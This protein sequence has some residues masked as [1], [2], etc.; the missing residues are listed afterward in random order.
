MDNETEASVG[1]GAALSLSGNLS[2]IATHHGA[3]TTTADGTATGSTAVGASIALGFVDDSALSTLARGVTAG[4][5][6][7]LAAHGDGSSITTAKASAAGEASGGTADGQKSSK[8]SQANT[9]SGKTKGTT[10]SASSD[11]GSVSVGAALAVNVSSSTAR[12][13]VNDGLTVVAGN[14]GAG[15]LSLLASN[16]MDAKAIADGSA[17]T[18]SGGTAVGVAVSI[19]VA[20]MTNEAIVGAGTTVTADSLTLSAIMKNVSSNV[21]HDFE[22]KST[23]GAS[24]GDVG[25]A[26][27]FALS[28]VHTET[29]AV[30][31]RDRTDQPGSGAASLALDGGAVSMTATNTTKSDVTATAAAA[32]GGSSTGVGASI[33]LGIQ[34]NNTDAGIEDGLNHTVSG[35]ASSLQAAATANHTFT[36]AATAGAKGGTAVG[37]AIAIAYVEN[38]TQAVIGS[39]GGG[40]VLT[41]GTLGAVADYIGSTV[42]TADAKASGSTAVGLTIGLNIGFADTDAKIARSITGAGA[43]NVLADGIM[44]STVDVSASAGGQSSGGASSDSETSNKTGVAQGKGGG[45]KAP[46]QTGSSSVGTANTNSNTQSGQGTGSGGTQ[47][48]AAVAVNYLDASTD[49]LIANNVTIGASGAVKVEVTTQVTAK[50][51]A[52]ATAFDSNATTGVAAAVGLNISEVDAKARIGN[53]ANVTGSSVSVKSVLP[54][55]AEHSYQVRALAG[56]A[57][58]GT[59][60][61]GSI[62]VNYLDSSSVA[63]IGNFATVTATGAGGVSV[64]ADNFNE[65][66]NLA[67]GAAL[68][69]SSSAGVGIAVAV[70]IVNTLETK[71]T[72][73]SDSTIN[74]NN[75]P[76]KVAADA[77]LVPFTENF[78]LAGLGSVPLSFTN[79][80]AGVAASSGGS[81][82]GGSASVNVMFIRTT[83]SVGANTAI[84]AGGDIDVTADDVMTLFT[85][86]GGIGLS[87]G[88]A[89]VGIGIDVNVIDRETK[90]TIGASADLITTGGDIEVSADSDDD[91]T[92]IAVTFGV[93][94]SGS[95]VS[96]SIGVLVLLTDT[97]TT[98]SDGT[99]LNRTRL[100]AGGDVTVRA[101][102]DADVFMLAGGL[103]YGNSAGIGIASTVFVH[104]DNVIASIGTFGDVTTGGAIGLNVESTSV[105]DVLLIAAAG[106]VTGGSVG[107]GGSVIVSVMTETTKATV[108]SSTTV[109]ATDIGS[110]APGARV[111]ADSDTDILAVAGAIGAAAGSAGIGAGVNVHTLTKTTEAHIA[112]SAN[113]EAEGNVTVEAVSDEVMK[114]FSLAAGGGSSIGVGISADVYVF[115]LTTRAYIGNSAI[116]RT[117]G[118]VLV[119]A[120]DETEADLIVGGASVGGTGGV[121][122]AVGVVVIDKIVDAYIGTSAHVTGEGHDAVSART[123]KFVAGVGSVKSGVSESDLSLSGGAQPDAADLEVGTPAGVGM[124]DKDADND[125]TDDVSD[126]PGLSA[127]QTSEAAVNANFRGVAV[128]ASSKDDVESMSF[129]LAAG[130]TFGVGVAAAVNVVDVDT[131]ATIGQ[132][133]QINQSVTGSANTGQSV[134]IAAASDFNHVGIGVGAA[135]GGSAGVAPG[136][137]VSVVEVT[138]KAQ[139]GA[140]TTVDARDDVAV[141]ATAEESFLIIA[142]GI[143]ASGA[144]ALGGGVSVITVNDETLASI[145]D[146]ADV[147][148]GG[149][150]AVLAEDDSTVTIITGGVGIGIGGAGIGASVGI[151]LFDK[152]TD[153]IIGANAI[154]NAKGAGTGY[155]EILNGDVGGDG[156]FTRGTAHGVIVQAD[157]TESFTNVSFAGAG[158]VYAGIAGAIGVTVIDSDTTAQIGDNA[159]INQGSGNY[160]VLANGVGPDQGVWVG[161]SNRVELLQLSIGIA[162]G[163]AGIAGAI[164]IG[165]IAN[166]VNATIGTGA[167]VRARSMVEVNAL[168]DK[169]LDGFT[170][171]GAGGLVGLGASVSVYSLGSTFDAGYEDNEGNSD[172]AIEGDGTGDGQN[173]ADGE[174][175][176]QANASSGQVGGSIGEMQGEAA[177]PDPGTSTKDSRANAGFGLAQ[178]KLT[179]GSATTSGKLGLLTADP[180]EPGVIAEVKAGGS[181]VTAGSVGVAAHET[182]EADMVS[183][184]LAVG[185]V[186]AGAAV[187]ILNLS[188]NVQ[189]RLGGSVT[190]AGAV[191]VTANGKRVADMLT[192]GLQAGFVGV[193]AAVS[194]LSDNSVQGAEVLGGASI[195]DASSVLVKAT[196]T[197][198][199]TANTY[200]LQG[201]V[202][203]LGVNFTR[204]SADDGDASTLDTYATIGNGADIGETQSVGTVTVEATSTIDAYAETVGVAIGLVAGGFNFSF[205]DVTPQVK[206]SIGNNVEMDTTGLVAL[207]A[208]T[209]HDANSRLI[210]ASVG[211]V[212]VGVS[213]AKATIGTAVTASIGSGFEASL[214]GL[215]LLASHNWGT[216]NRGAHAYAVAAGGGIVSGQGAVPTANAN[217]T[218]S[219][220]IGAGGNISANSGNISVTSRL[221]NFAEADALAVSIGIAGVGA[222]IAHANANGSVTA[223]V[224]GN[225]TGGNNLDVKAMG[226][227]KARAQ[228]DAATGGLIAVT[229]PIASAVASPTLTARLD[230]GA[231]I[232]GAL[233]V[234]ANSEGEAKAETLSITGGLAGIGSMT[235]EATVSPV[236]ISAIGGGTIVA[237][238]VAV[239]AR[240]NFNT[241]KEA[242]ARTKAAGFT[243]VGVQ[244]NDAEATAKANLD[245]YIEGGTKV[246]APNG[247]TISATGQNKA[248]ARTDGLNVGILVAVGVTDATAEAS[249]TAKAGIRDSASLPAT[250]AYTIGGLN[251][252][253]T[254]QDTASATVITAGGGIVSVADNDAV[255]KANPVV[256]AYIGANTSILATGN[257]SVA[258]LARPEADGK[259]SGTSGGLVDVGAALSDVDV[260]P[261]VTASIKSASVIDTTGSVTVKA[262]ALPQSNNVPNYQIILA[263]Q[264]EDT[265][266][267]TSHGLETGDVVE[268]DAD[269]NPNTTGGTPIS[270]LSGVIGEIRENDDGSTTTVFVNR[271]YGVIRIDDNTVAF[272]NEFAGNVIDTDT[273]II[274]FG[275]AHN[276]ISG[277]RVKYYKAPG[278]V[279]DVSGLNTAATYFVLVVDDLSIKLVDTQ[280]KA[281]NPQN[282]FKSF[283]PTNVV[284]GTDT[285]TLPNV[286]DLA[287]GD[288]VTYDAPDAT[289]FFSRQVDVT[290]GAPN[291]DGSANLTDNA[292]ANNIHFVNDNGVSTAHGFVE[293]EHVVYNVEAIS[294]AVIPIGGLT[295][296]VTYRV[297]VINSTTIQLK[298]NDVIAEEVH[299][300][301]D[302]GTQRIVRTDGESWTANGFGVGDSLIVTGVGDNNG[303]Y[304]ITAASGATLTLSAA[305]DF[306]AT[307]VND[308]MDFIRGAA[309]GDK[310]QIKWDDGNWTSEGFVAGMVITVTNAGANNGSYTIDSVSTS[311]LTLTSS[312]VVVNATNDPS[313]VERSA[314]TKTFD[315]DVIALAPV[316]TTVPGNPPNVPDDIHS[317]INAKN[318]PIGGL[319]DGKT[320]YVRTISGNDITL[321]DAPA[322]ALVVLTPTSIPAGSGY[323]AHKLGELAVDISAG[324]SSDSYQLR[325]DITGATII[326][327]QTL[328]APGGV[329]LAVI[330]PQAGDG[331]SSTYAKGVSG[332]FIGVSAHTARVDMNPTVNADISAG[333]VLAGGDVSIIT[334]A[335]TDAKGYASN[336]AGAFIAVG[337]A[338]VISNQKLTS[339]ASVGGGT[340]ITAGNNFLIDSESRGNATLSTTTKTGGFVGLAEATTNSDMDFETKST[341]GANAVILAGDLARLY[342]TSRVRGDAKAN[343]TGVG[344]GGDGTATARFTTNNSISE[345]RL[346]SGAILEANRSVLE[347]YVQN[348]N[349]ASDS[350]GRGGGFYSEGEADSRSTLEANT[351]VAI[352]S[353]AELTGWEGVDLIAINRNNTIKTDAYS[354]SSGLFG[355]VDSDAFSTADLDARV[356]G[357]GGALVTAGPRD[358]GDSELSQFDY[359]EEPPGEQRLAFFA[360][361]TNTD[362][363]TPNN[364]RV[365]KRSLAGGGA[366]DG[367]TRILTDEIAFSSNVLI[368]SGRSPEL[369]VK[370]IVVSPNA[371][372]EEAVNVTVNDTSGGG[373]ANEG[374]GD[375]ILSAKVIV[376]D[377][378]N[379]G[380]GDVAFVSSTISGSTG[381]WTFRETLQRIEILN[382]SDK[383]IQIND[384]D[385]TADRQPLVTLNPFSGSGAA[386]RTLTFDIEADVAPTLIEITN[387]GAGDIE[388]NGFIN[389]PI[390]ITSIV[391]TQA[392]VLATQSRPTSLVRSHTLNIDAAMNVGSLANRVVA[393]IVDAD[394]IPES[395]EFRTAQVSGT[396]DRIFVGLGAKFYTGQL[397]RYDAASTVIGG[398]T[399]LGYYYVTM[400]GDGQS[401]TL[402]LTEGGPAINLSTSG[403]L[404]DTHTLT[405][406]E[407]FTVDAGDDIFLDVKALLRQDIV[408]G[409][410]V[411]VDRIAAGDDI[412]VLLRPSVVQ[413]G[414]GQS[415]G[416]RVKYT[417]NQNQVFHTFFDTPLG[418]LPVGVSRGVYATGTTEIDSTYDFRGINPANGVRQLAGLISGLDTITGDIKVVAAES[419]P[420]DTTINVLGITEVTQTGEAAGEGHI[421]VLT[422]GYIALT[423]KTGDM[424]VESIK[425]TNSDVLLYS[426]RMIIDA[427]N[428]SG[429]TAVPVVAA[430]VSGVNITMVAGTGLVNPNHADVASQVAN[431]TRNISSPLRG[432]IGTPTNFLEIDVDI[433]G[434]LVLTTGVLQAYDIT[435]TDETDGIFLDEVIGDLHVHTVQTLRDVSLRTTGGSG[436]ILDALDDDAANVIGQTIDLDAHGAGSD[437][438]EFADDLEI[439]SR[440]GSPADVDDV[441]LEATDN[442]YV[443]ETEGNLRL[444][445]AHTYDGDIRLTVRESAILGEDLVLLENGDVLFAEDDAPFADDGSLPGN[446]DDSPRF[447]ANGQVFAEQGAVLLLVGDNVTLHQ[448]SQ[449]LAAEGI[450]I[451]GDVSATN[452]VI[453]PLA[454]LD[455]GFGTNMVLRGR[456]IAGADVTAGSQVGGDPLGSAIA[457]V[458]APE[459]L[460]EIFGNVDVDTIQFGD[461]TGAG[462]TN[463]QGSPGYVFLGSKTRAYGSQDLDANNADGEDRY[464]VYYLQDTETQT[465]PN[466]TT[467][468]EHTLTLDGV[469][470]SDDYK[471]YTLGSNNPGLGD[472]GTD[473]NRNYVI[474]VLDT[475]LSN[476]GV[477]ELTI[478]G[479]DGALNGLDIDGNKPI[480]DIFLLRAATELPGET[481]DRPAYV[482]MV[483]G[484][485][486]TYTDTIEDN[487]PS[488]EVARINY[489]TA[490]NGRLTVEG[491]GGNDN[492]YSDDTTVIVSLQGGAGADSFQ[493]GQIFGTKRTDGLEEAPTFGGELLA[494][495]VFP[496]MVA[497]T[498]G[499]LSPGISAPLV[500]QGGTGNDEF[501]VYSNQAELRLEGDDNNDLFIVRAFA[502]AAVANVDWNGDGTIDQDDLPAVSADSNLDGVIN[503]A[504]ADTTPDDY[505]DDV[506]VLDENGVAMPIIGLGFSVARAPDIRAGGGEDE[507]QYN[508]NAPVA[509][510][511]GTGFDKLVILGT[512][513]ADDFAITDRGIFGAGLNV[514]YT[515]I[516][517]V[518]I[519]GLEGDDEFFVQST[520]FGVAYR[521]IGGLGSDTINVTGDVT[522]DIVTRELEG[523]SGAVDH[524]V[525]STGDRFYDG[526]V[527]DGFD[528]NVATA[529]EGIV[530]IDES[531]GFTAVREGGPVTTDSYTVKL[532]VQPLAG[533]FVYVTV[534]AARSPQEEADGTLINPSPLPN[535]L[536]DSI[537]LSTVDPGDAVT[538]GDFQHIITI[539]GIPTVINDRAV[540]LTF[541]SANWNVAQ[542]VHVYAP[543]DP[544]AEGDRVVVV[545][546]SVISDTSGVAPADFP[547]DYVDLFDAADVRNV[548]VLVRDNDTPGV[549]VLEVEPGT[550]IEDGRSLVIEGDVTTQLT[551]EVLV[552]LAKQPDDVVVVRLFLNT[553]SDEDIEIIDIAD[554]GN[555]DGRM[556]KGGDGYWRITFDDTASASA[557]QWDDQVHVGIKARDDITREDPHTAVISFQRDAV[558]TLDANYVFPNLRSGLGLLDI[559]VIDNETAGAVVLES[560]GNTLLNADGSDTDDY[561][562]RLTKEP[563]SDVQVAILTDGLADVVSVNGAAVTPAGYAVIGGLRPTQ[564][565]EGS[566]IF[567][568]DGGFGKVTRGTGA[569]LGS[570]VD[571]GFYV[572]Q[573]IRIG[574]GDLNF[575][576]DY[577]ITEV[578]VLGQFL[579]VDAAFGVAGPQEVLDTA[580]LSDLANVGTFTGMVEF[581]KVVEEGVDTYRM[582][583]VGLADDEA[584]WLAYGFVEGQRIRLDGTNAGDYKIAIIRGEND[585]KDDTIQFTA[586]NTPVVIDITEEVT[587]VRTAAFATFTP[588]NYYTQQTIE[589]QADVNYEVPITREGVKVF[590]VSTHYLSKLRG[591]LAVEGGPTGADRSLENGL[592]LPGEADDF[593]I[594]IGQQPP[595]S[596]QIDVL[597]IFNDTS[598]ED[599]NGV[600]SETTLRGFNMADDLNFAML[601]GLSAEDAAT[602]GESLNVPG[603]ISFGKV[604]F[605]PGGFG[606]NATQSTIEVVNLM[607]GEGND[608][609]D[610]VGTLNPAPSVQVT[611]L[612][613]VTPAGVS[614]GTIVREG[615]DWKAQGFLIGQTVK[616]EGQ[617]GEWTVVAIDDAVT[618]AG[619]DPNDNSILVLSGP[620]MALV[621]DGLHTITAFDKDVLTVDEVVDVVQTTAGGIVTRT[622]GSWLADGFALGQFVEIEEDFAQKEYEIVELS[623][624]MMKLTGGQL[625]PV[626]EAPRTI[627]QV[628]GVATATTEVTIDPTYTGGIV[629][630]DSGSWIDEGY[631]AG[632]L[633]TM[634]DEN[635]KRDFRIVEISEDGLSLTLEGVPL[636]GESDAV[637]TFYVQGIHGG[638]TVVHGGG[639]FNLESTGDMN[640]GSNG[641]G[642]VVLTRLDGRDW[643]KDRYEVGQI[644]QLEGETYTRT[645]LALQDASIAAPLNSALTWGDGSALLLSAPTNRADQ[646]AGTVLADG[647]YLESTANAL[648]LHVT[649]PFKA[650]ASGTMSIATFSTD[651]DTNNY[652]TITRN[653]GDWLI[654][655]FYD[656]QVVY[657]SGLAGGFTVSDLTATVMTLQNVA[658][659]PQTNV[660]LTVFG[661]D[662]TKDSILNSGARVG[663]DH[664]TIS[665]GAG[666]DSPLV[667]YGD[668]SQ[669]GMWYSGEAN[670]VLGLEFGEKPFDPFPQLP[671]GENEDDEWVFPLANPYDLAGN[672]VIDASALFAGA[673]AGNLPSVGLTIYG[674]KGNDTII[675]S[676]AGD[677]LAGGSGDD[678]IIGQRGT[679]HIYGDSGVNVNIFTRA[680]TI[681]TIDASPLPTASPDAGTNGTTLEPKKASGL[682]DAM[683]AGR[684]IIHGDG[685]G[686]APGVLGDNDDIIFADHGVI[687]MFV[688]D[689]NLP[690]LLLQRIQ[691]TSLGLVLE[692]NSAEVQNGNDDVVFGGLDRDVIVGG[693][694]HDMLDGDEQDDLIFGDNV[695]LTRMAGLDGIIADGN[696]FDDIANLRFQTLAGT[697]LYSRTDQPVP[698]GFD[699]PNADTS[700]LLLTDG[701]ARNYRDPDGA[702]WWAEYDVDYADLHTVEFDRGLAGVGSFGNDYIAGSQ[703]HDEI[704]GQLGDDVI[705]GDGGIELAFAATSH[706]GASRTPGGPSDP[707]GP[708]SVVASFEA[709]TDGEDYIEGGGGNDVIFGGLGQDDIVGGSSSFYSLDNSDVD[710]ETSPLLHR[711]PDGDDIIFGGAGTNI[712]RNDIGDA[713]ITGDGAGNTPTNVI[714]TTATGHADDADTIVG[715][716]G[717]II[718]IVGINGNDVNPTGN[719]ALP[720]YLAFN[721]DNYGSVKIIVRGVH[722][723]DYT[724]GGPDF[725]PDLFNVADFYDVN[726]LTSRIDIGGRDE[727]HGE[728]GDDT[729]YL[730]AGHDIAFGDGQDDDIIGGWGNDW[731]SGG[732]GQDG[733]LGDDGR[734]FTSRNTAGVITQFSEPLYAINLLLASDPDPRHPQVIHGNVIDEFVYTPGQVQKAILNPGGALKKTFDITPY[735]LTPDAL[736]LGDEPLFD[737]N[738]ADDVIFGGLGEDFLH[739]A[740]GDD[741][742]AGG[743]ALPESYIQLYDGDP[744][745]GGTDVLGLVRTDFTRPWNPGDILHFGADTNPWHVNNHVASRL[746]E[747]FLYDEYDARR[748]ILF[749]AADGSVWKSGSAEG[750]KQYF[751]NQ[752]S[753]EGVLVYGAV[754]FSP[755]GTPLTFAYRNT[756]GN[757]VIFG[758]LGNDWMVGGTGRDNIYAGW[759]NDLSNADD[760]LTTNGSLNDATDSHPV[761]EDRVF[762]G[763]G[764][765]I[766]IGN[767]GGDRLIDWVGEWNS[768]IVPFAPFGIATVSRQVEPQLPEFLY[769]LSASD[770]ADPTRDTDTGINPTRNGEPDGELGLITQRDHGLWQEQ[771]GGPTDP[772]PGN[773]PGGPRDV[774]RTADFNNGSLGSFAIDSG[775][776]EV[777]GGA[778]SVAAASLGK[779]AAAVFYLDQYLPIY[780]EISA[781]I[782]ADKPTAGWKANAYVIFDYFSPTDF[783]FAGI[784][785]STN[786]IEMGHRTDSGWVVDVQSTTPV[787][788]KPG[789]FYN[790]L[791][792][793]NGTNV[794]VLVDNKSYFTYTFAPRVI[795]GVAYGLNKGFVGVGSDNSRGVFDNVSARVLPPQWTFQYTETF[796]SGPG[797]LFD[798]WSTGTWTASGGRYTGTPWAGED[799][800]ISLVDLGIDG[801]QAASILDLSAT[802]NT[803]GRAGLVFDR[804]GVNDFKFV[805]IDA[806]TDQ[807]LIGHSTARG[808]WAIDAAVARTINA[809]ADYTL[810]LALRGTSVSVTLN[811]QMA[812]SHSFNALTV[813]GDFGVFATGSGGSFDNVTVKTNDPAFASGSGSGMMATGIDPVP[814]AA[815]TLTQAQLDAIVASAIGMWTDALGAGDPRL[816]A[817]SDIQV[818]I[819]DLAGGTLGYTDGNLVTLD[820]DA[821]GYG[822]FID[823]SPVDNGEFRVRLDDSVLTATPNS[824]AFG[825]M[826]LLTVVMHEVGHVLGLDH[827]DAMSFTVMDDDLESGVRYLLGPEAAT[828]PAART[829]S[830]GASGGLPSFDLDAG[831]GASNARIDW[832]APV[833]KG[834][835]ATLSPYAP[836]SATKSATANFTDFLMKILKGR[837]E[838]QSEGFDQM[839]RTLLGK[840]R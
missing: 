758:D 375:T 326:G 324:S 264:T 233:V 435:T 124:T 629:T 111:Y 44:V 447:V 318:L 574:T 559:E 575:D 79:F 291:P 2:A 555:L 548:E 627:N 651:V 182:I 156:S 404:T 53:N 15:G 85:A 710:L 809:G 89:G 624:T 269:G 51:I 586:E 179:S 40:L 66:Q 551:D 779:D 597:N 207:R 751:L 36:T 806:V 563:L 259:T 343:A 488:N 329:S 696:I 546:H 547:V 137:D 373:G 720:N 217:A 493:I 626:A 93:S 501:R 450:Q 81:A 254:S 760:V 50:A 600:M 242:L 614:G 378:V 212:G 132:F 113:V 754:T 446:H 306:K 543:D 440:V 692:I 189:A 572:G 514:R 417:N 173:T 748:T 334:N 116:V 606:T 798:G 374:T 755:N 788:I 524:L 346:G 653:S 602:F 28:V 14:P 502:I 786:K 276:F 668:T 277:D 198:D 180:G 503:F 422:N 214:G 381:T 94:T 197:Q 60:V 260:N 379:P 832:D 813:D 431:P 17:K 140:S 557:Y 740:S 38:V 821:A 645:I 171:S 681:S 290:I 691:T 390:G 170:L 413:M 765:D 122:A 359:A 497:T 125:G 284:D 70:N 127:E 412:D 236:L 273:E 567:E 144:F 697:L 750:K 683:N 437:I 45:S 735:N 661:F 285:I 268:Y 442:I 368:L 224:D 29:N 177:A 409:Y 247:V 599:G 56:A 694:G 700:G 176:A 69:V 257:I 623:A 837:G 460:T 303:T 237:N 161:A 815:E 588:A 508:V 689:P 526:V 520:A 232:Q 87:G 663:G 719:L 756:D 78:D 483:Y 357:A 766:L 283:T 147:E 743:E 550:T 436:S 793:I 656:G 315:Q 552:Q 742:V 393:D 463:T 249:G 244:V 610:I 682:L 86:A 643:A 703:G 617:V 272:G 112:S 639:N 265:I 632:H 462:G 818:T 598:K 397:V 103:A 690:S 787:Q 511:G 637:K 313:T 331:V 830:R 580:I 467:V 298:R 646:P 335:E 704:F 799:I 717:N 139:L 741:A 671:D 174:A 677:H 722:H 34:F 218:V 578:D 523:V 184:Q 160:A 282:N 724:P 609:L 590:P 768:Y 771:T 812:L 605:G 74:A 489:D 253:A 576:G 62:A 166:D 165:S 805:A 649:E 698:A 666:P 532:A 146:S 286:T 361:A 107:V 836:P 479:F 556:F 708:L 385:V 115:D 376:N 321:K 231:N 84:N 613:D 459:H 439:N 8:T 235:T 100:D 41:G 622:S 228:A 75:G 337:E 839:G 80:A 61:G 494:Q 6:I 448:N 673:P 307:R 429:T 495:D 320:Y 484:Q 367:A 202:V 568:N 569:D 266:T 143:A 349:I 725:R 325:I 525:S 154:I 702:P 659:T 98:V 354:R 636:T 371:E 542:T 438:G 585:S 469:S 292:A 490:L 752:V 59:T 342:T 608:K 538:D 293:G 370:K 780:Y 486:T 558:L 339:L 150:V 822:W 394:G 401:L 678:L 238:S 461:P 616:I 487:E 770:G 452:G 91:I 466:K 471:V 611:N 105:D 90:A 510:D 384:I 49:A 644:I 664:I 416:V 414:E 392:S 464:I 784:N 814:G 485:P 194:V 811:G 9:K 763:A 589:L 355:H 515:T 117:E 380:P 658:L 472:A 769:A 820:L 391:N 25:V 802:V 172:D 72:I 215:E 424:R 566:L 582:T 213:L 641:D 43:V 185:A 592:K 723:L 152:T 350:D 714:T 825:R 312:Q 728:A 386:N 737:A 480:D 141:I 621:A 76:V 536:G 223:D 620:S 562:I 281:L 162:G 625:A 762:G 395:F 55:N 531:G 757:D 670:N 527:V 475:G 96:G 92:S 425:S 573:Q 275:Q 114:T 196:N 470:E 455:V 684:D 4:G 491:M 353:N 333:Q 121:S 279:T 97:L 454:N 778:L 615:F 243:A 434:N 504:D 430:D 794:S 405:G 640:V 169:S 190:A 65:I 10:Q 330:A 648:S 24:G 3:T 706:A 561:T 767:T 418:Q 465:S 138:T 642:S 749:D 746:G 168:S 192:I 383:T 631:L 584:G 328:L 701:I 587:T 607:L 47:V 652:S 278:T 126:A 209:D 35:T 650:Q 618:P 792:A 675:G 118:S 685:E 39:G 270:G 604:S 541:T 761:Y 348:S 721:Y 630:R 810:A 358:P 612:F 827:D 23:S 517:V 498:R 332:S 633:V 149:D 7:G 537:W 411:N 159:Q 473:F 200:T 250:P 516:E 687:K 32:G 807:V 241:T 601:Y 718:R 672:D 428:D 77:S 255:A 123:G 693:A 369:V 108:G 420:S 518:E 26:G 48:A 662:L 634:V 427:L 210:G 299:F 136:V 800:A 529:Q 513:F 222:S 777:K 30:F 99:S 674:G 747:F 776:F 403:A 667:V 33:A 496:A 83:A 310:D 669:D 64:M 52:D 730:G 688:D 402:S 186:G 109:T 679:D 54:L 638:L 302:D 11:S 256:D 549:Y 135:V 628:G 360:Q 540:V 396:S 596:Q 759:G 305:P 82:I 57:S 838:T 804:Y 322:G 603:G 102:G 142:A 245:S 309:A 88:N 699:A 507:V 797:Q 828:P 400:A 715:D 187:S 317:L 201:G 824:D 444:V 110:D 345:V 246:T 595:E 323:A 340:I 119:Q 726:G 199:L 151:G 773:I 482:A 129:S 280:D 131:T 834:W 570:F 468:A 295:D 453:D 287:V 158:G 565:F 528:Y 347:A 67:G 248:T 581:T 676:Q 801:L 477:D 522:E 267:V 407:T 458:T 660:A 258:A 796:G 833:T 314:V 31:G 27:S 783:K 13:S 476:D 274:T 619:Q 712:A 738:Y 336:G 410:V 772:Q 421:T 500:A 73:G 519:D 133:A 21:K 319:E 432:G 240:H 191:N 795:E 377:I 316:K 16:N 711:R 356:S 474:N 294:G 445:L 781:S 774:L 790:V 130:G 817:L 188:S 456:I 128:S 478:F 785:V 195:D 583:I 362:T 366:A 441:G 594:A 739:G 181:I 204:I 239:R 134:L 308:D 506:I 229:V 406:A 157:S 225:I 63:E 808:G 591:P 826:D 819:A 433:V 304:T 71:A 695:Y 234:E 262:E 226:D 449:I 271:T 775:V 635:G 20:N 571:E 509:V 593:L 782:K 42:T 388:L 533:Q 399:D 535:G 193:G 579:R 398:L 163:I 183:G 327:T 539:N 686:S 101:E 803:Q 423:E 120:R 823:V 164:S 733:I 155:D 288:A 564:M 216:T 18:T 481:A 178:G 521:V 457:T 364:A 499:W 382:K 831:G 205:I 647:D 352:E 1:T 261:M 789:V 713:T 68:S 791:V 731:I 545:Q 732:T 219:A 167:D 300:V 577:Y 512:E 297:H 729:I 104:T 252:D 175:N 419:D 553:F 764:L 835:G 46:T 19:N 311:T 665:G 211:A 37:G 351:L 840:G 58:K 301:Y 727:V 426:P 22:A 408:V 560:E 544:R 363:S 716:N 415:G 208:T 221:R 145:G 372:I 829:S 95:G 654:E 5:A 492:F 296:G 153:A 505:T 734:I 387:T 251:I 745:D 530:I 12:A 148:A 106:G 657:V 680:L 554:P 341:I 389:N 263:S 709:G 655:G 344:L 338:F 707:V 534:S 203:A 705:Q 230:G 816:A 365:S 220:T 451:Y 227:N 744:N 206:A 736:G 289:T 753:D 443:T